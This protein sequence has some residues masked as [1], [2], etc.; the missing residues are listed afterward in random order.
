[1]HCYETV[2]ELAWHYH[3]TVKALSSDYHGTI[4]ALS[5][6]YHGTIM[7]L[8]WNLA[9]N[10][11]W[12]HHKTIMA[13]SDTGGRKGCT[14]RPL[15]EHKRQNGQTGVLHVGLSVLAQVTCCN[16]QQQTQ[17]A[18]I[19]VM[20]TSAPFVRAAPAPILDPDSSPIYQLPGP[21]ISTCEAS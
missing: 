6:H 11:S 1:M 16:L 3:K 19:S 13:N 18:T 12:N 20:H 10:L 21:V 2:V 9:W 14:W 15:D 8:S 17:Q 4:M 5:W 7:A